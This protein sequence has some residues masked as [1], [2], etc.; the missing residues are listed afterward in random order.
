MGAIRSNESQ[1]QNLHK[2]LSAFYYTQSKNYVW[3][4]RTLL[5]VAIR[6][7]LF[8]CLCSYYLNI[9]VK[10]KQKVI[11]AVASNVVDLG[12]R[13]LSSILDN[14]QQKKNISLHRIS[15]IWFDCGTGILKF[16]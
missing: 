1:A 15:Y 10:R 4:A 5:T 14:L 9:M 13:P 12:V 7:F 2:F 8:L 6:K 11:K 3:L 16:H